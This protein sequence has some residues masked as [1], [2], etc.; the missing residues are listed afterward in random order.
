MK[1]MIHTDAYH[2][3]R[4]VD[5]YWEASA[6]PLRVDASALEEDVYCDIAIVGAGFTGLSAALRLR[7]LYGADVRVLDAGDIGWGASGRNGG[8]CCLGGSK[9]GW[10]DFI[11]KYG[12]DEAKKFFAVQREAV[13]LVRELC[14]RYG[15]DASL[16][17]SGE[18]QLAHKPDRFD[19]L[20]QERNFLKDTL[21]FETELIEAE[22]LAERGYGGP[23]FHGG[24]L[25]PHGFGLH[26]LAY[27]RG[28]AA[29][30]AGNAAR[31][32]GRTR[33][34]RWEQTKTSHVLI[35][36]R[37]SVTADQVIFATNGY[38]PEGMLRPLAGR[39]MPVLSNIIVTRPLTV[40]ER[41]A[42]GWTADTMAFD[43]RNLL[44]YFRLLPDGRFMFGGRGGTNSA[45]RSALA[46]ERSLRRDFNAMFPAWAHVDHTHFWR[47][48]VC[49]SSDLV[50]FIGSINKA[51]TAWAALA[52][53]GNGVSMATWSGRALADLVAGNHEVANIPEFMRR[54]P[55]RF[56]FPKLRNLYFKSAY[57]AY[58]LQDRWL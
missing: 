24:L 23:G 17:G 43:T 8:F 54:P 47:G 58:G 19:E 3:D 16:S 37:G 6:L 11:K 25:N 49:L 9:L 36:E 40:E 33:V 44:H 41:A 14:Q 56:P 50:P 12:I 30:A 57:M 18:L 5:S 10:P 4:T 15:I 38:T 13:G 2:F 28:L 20:R 45:D 53:H 39:I 35:T 21:D 52:Y 48:L 27:V 26:P 22:Q 32:H 34:K 51:R 42:Q 1:S 46:S 31:L 29:T 55:P 7:T